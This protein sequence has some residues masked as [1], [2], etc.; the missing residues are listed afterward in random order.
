MQLNFLLFFLQIINILKKK[1]IACYV[2]SIFEFLTHFLKWV[3]T[4]NKTINKT[5]NRE[6]F[7]HPFN[8]N[9]RYSKIH[10]IFERATST[11]TKSRQGSVRTKHKSLFTFLRCGSNV[12][13]IKMR[14]FVMTGHYFKNKL[15]LDLNFK[16]FLTWF[17]ILPL[18]IYNYKLVTIRTE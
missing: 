15:S 16:H 11:V 7:R 17:F 3:F 13:C 9:N 6:Y 10:F 5:G 14:L 2:N 1:T 8:Q 12:A 4:V 18:R